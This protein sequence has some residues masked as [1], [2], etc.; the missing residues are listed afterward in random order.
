VVSHPSTSDERRRL[1]LLAFTG[2][3]FGLWLAGRKLGTTCARRNVAA[4]V[5]TA[6]VMVPAALRW[7]GWGAFGAWLLGHVAWGTYLASA[8]WRGEAGSERRESG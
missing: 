3:V 4:L 8:V 6:A 7:G 1:A 2:H 5:L